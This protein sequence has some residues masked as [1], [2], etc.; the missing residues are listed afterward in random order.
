MEKKSIPEQNGSGHRMEVTGVGKSGDGV[1]GW[2]G[3]RWQGREVVDSGVGN[4]FLCSVSHVKKWQAVGTLVVP[5][6]FM[7]CVRVPHWTLLICSTNWSSQKTAFRMTDR[8]ELQWVYRT[9]ILQVQDHIPLCY[10]NNYP[11]PTSGCDVASL[12]LSERS[13]WNVH[14]VTKW[15]HVTPTGMF[16]T[17]LC[18]F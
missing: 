15:N 12:W 11:S 13:F 9:E 3:E 10:L 14:K 16:K 18:L 17:I 5:I 7:L 8:L 2:V 1:S 4:G 6:C